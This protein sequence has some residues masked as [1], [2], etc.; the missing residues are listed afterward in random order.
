MKSNRTLL[1]ALVVVA[2][3]LAIQT[4][5]AEIKGTIRS[6]GDGTATVAL[7]GD[8]RPSIGDKAEIY[9]KVAGTEDDISVATGSVLRV[10]ADSVEL[11]IENATGDVAKDQL[12][13][14]TSSNPQKRPG[15]P[16][17]TPS[18][19]PA[20]TTPSATPVVTA[21]PSASSEN[22][23]GLS[24][25]GRWS[26]KGRDGEVKS[27]IFKSDGTMIMPLPDGMAL[28]GKYVV[29]YAASPPRFEITDFEFLPPAHLTDEEVRQFHQ[30]L[31][32]ERESEPLAAK[33]LEDTTMIGEIDD[34]THVRIDAFTKAQAAEHPKLPPDA[35]RMTKLAPGEG[36][37][38]FASPPPASPPPAT[39]A[40]S[41]IPEPSSS[42]MAG[43]KFFAEGAALQARGEY[44]RAIA[45][46]TMSIDANP[47][48][49][50]AY[51]NRARCYEKKSNWP[52]AMDDLNRTISLN[53]NW[54]AAYS[55]RSFVRVHQRSYGP[56]LLLDCNKALAL[57]EKDGGAYLR[58]GIYY[59]TEGAMNLAEA[60]WKKAI[61]LD[62]DNKK[63]VQQNRAF[64]AIPRKESRRKR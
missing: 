23:K 16:A 59:A 56:P 35:N 17:A 43:Q 41:S 52:R 5:A 30:K 57:D 37:P 20:V 24:L 32:Q 44:D 13:R 18:P 8:D 21:T 38:L 45:A 55:D 29:D 22:A 61:E 33:K 15:P 46:Y 47:N 49:P 36:V 39:P 28:T 40:P 64:F 3:I 54:P 1:G 27:L 12:V 63:Y 4:Q 31:K 34:A 14:I 48:F 11:K 19:V 7:Q 50:G 62:P 51:F 26:G 2:V 9:F 58:R 10:E 42:E 60:D 25:L 53:P 6:V